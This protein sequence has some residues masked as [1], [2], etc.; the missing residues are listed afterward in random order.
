MV[1]NLYELQRYSLTIVLN[2]YLRHYLNHIYFTRR[3]H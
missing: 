2:R 3:C 1:S